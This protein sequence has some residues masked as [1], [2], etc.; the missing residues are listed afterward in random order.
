M[1]LYNPIFY[2]FIHLY[3]SLS[4]SCVTLAHATSSVSVAS[5]SN[6]IA[7]VTY[8]EEIGFTPTKAIGV[9]LTNTGLM[10]SSIYD[11]TNTGCKLHVFN[12]STT[13]GNFSNA[14]DVMLVL[15]K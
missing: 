8:D 10:I 11:L 9:I 13:N 5:K 7:T 14:I 2:D 3:A 4:S 1:I 15:Y 12:T 6:S